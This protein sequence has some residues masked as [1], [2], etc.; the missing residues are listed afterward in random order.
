MERHK[1]LSEKSW[2]AIWRR[3]GSELEVI[4]RREIKHV[5]TSM[6]ILAFGDAF[7]SALLHHPLA[8]SSGMIEME[9]LFG[10]VSDGA[11]D[12]DCR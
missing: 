2:V 7:E 4:R 11:V 10:Q 3:A 1:R 12:Q 9:R 8:A 5:D 6:A